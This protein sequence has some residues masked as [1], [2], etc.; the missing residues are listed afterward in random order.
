MKRFQFN[1]AS[2][3]RIAKN[4]DPLHRKKTWLKSFYIGIVLVA[5]GIFFL[6]A[7]GPEFTVFSCVLLGCSVF[8]FV[9]A[10]IAKNRK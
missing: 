1:H 9:D 8:V 5:L 2:R 7:L 10:F 6:L 3:D 4:E